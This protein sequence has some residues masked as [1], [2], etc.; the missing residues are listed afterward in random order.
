MNKYNRV[1]HEQL[2]TEWPTNELFDLKYHI[3]DKETKNSQDIRTLE[4]V[5][6][7]IQSR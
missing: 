1:I 2:F 3:E 5:N 6:K 7:V 4:V